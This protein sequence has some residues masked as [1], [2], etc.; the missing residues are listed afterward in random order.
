[1]YKPYFESLDIWKKVR[2]KYTSQGITV[3]IYGSK[4]G[5]RASLSLIKVPDD[6]RGEGLAKKIMNELINLA[7]SNEVILTLTPSSD[8]GSN[9]NRLIKFY[10]TFGFVDN[11]G[12]KKD[13]EISDS[14]YRL[15]S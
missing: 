3:D 13:Y 14:M 1:M 6:K 9:K 11:K 7:D 4:D 5:K 2:D 15:P 12:K 10:K 8:F